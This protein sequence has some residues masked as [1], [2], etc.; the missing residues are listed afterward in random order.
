MSRESCVADEA[1]SP[2]REVR[3][4]RGGT[5]G[6]HEQN[7]AEPKVRHSSTRAYEGRHKAKDPAETPALTFVPSGPSVRP[8]LRTRKPDLLAA[9]MK[10]KLH[11][12]ASGSPLR[13]SDQSTCSAGH[14]A[15]QIDGKNS[16]TQVFLSRRPRQT[17]LRPALV[18]GPR[19]TRDTG[20]DRSTSR[21]AC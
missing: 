5:E 6:S 7:E 9:S 17:A 15:S 1:G 12:S 8:F 4:M 16:R 18:T 14:S 11:R 21:T 13:R 20:P 19:R 2:S 10:P 3:R